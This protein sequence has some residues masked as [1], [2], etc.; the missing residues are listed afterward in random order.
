MGKKNMYMTIDTETVGGASAPTGAYNYGGVIH[1]KTG[2]IYATFSILVMEHYDEIAKDDYAKRNFPIYRE[3][4]DKGDITAVASE[5]DAMQIIRNLCRFYRV[6]YVMAYNTGFDFCKTK[7]RELLDEFEFIDIYLMALQTITHLKSYRQFCIDHEKWSASGK[8]C[9]T[10][11]ESVFGF[12]NQNAQY[13]EEHTALNDALIE[14]AIFARCAAM[15]KRYAKNVHMWDC[16]ERNK[17]FPKRQ[18]VARGVAQTT[19]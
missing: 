14:M 7:C 11:A 12:I 17:C 16:K 13:V 3:R 8:T 5:D 6:N 9:S 19:P 4:L 10:T 15:K 18:N 1:D 2:H